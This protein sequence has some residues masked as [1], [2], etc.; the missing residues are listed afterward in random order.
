MIMKN[1]L[2]LTV[3]WVVGCSAPSMMQMGTDMA[4]QQPG[5]MTMTA[6]G[7]PAGPYGNAIGETFPPLK[8]EGYVATTGAVIVNTLPYQNYTMDDARMSGKRYA[9]V[10]VSAFF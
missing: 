3:W 5:D 4:Q 2:A 1:L 6:A 7:Y 9:M 8:W 10:H